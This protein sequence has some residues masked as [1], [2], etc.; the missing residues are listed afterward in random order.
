MSYKEL[1]CVIFLLFSLFSAVV[2]LPWKRKHWNNF[3]G[4]LFNENGIQFHLVEMN[5]FSVVFVS[6]CTIFLLK[7]F[8]MSLMEN[9][10]EKLPFL[11]FY[12]VVSVVVFL[13]LWFCISFFIKKNVYSSAIC[14]FVYNLLIFE[15]ITTSVF[16]VVLFIIVEFRNSVVYT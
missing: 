4:F 11:C 1:Y 13:V 2:L 14:L 10:K 15:N 6:F 12:H 8:K 5:F 7:H 16:I 9:S 3:F